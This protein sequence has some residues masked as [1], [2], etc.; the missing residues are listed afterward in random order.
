MMLQYSSNGPAQGS[1]CYVSTGSLSPT[2]A[3]TTIKFDTTVQFSATTNVSYLAGVVGSAVAQSTSPL[4]YSSGNYSAPLAAF[5]FNTTA[6]D[7]RWKCVASVNGATPMVADTGVI[8]TVDGNVHQ[9][10]IFIDDVMSTMHFYIDSA[11]VCL[12]TAWGPKLPAASAV[13]PYLGLYQTSSFGSPQ[14][15]ALAYLWLEANR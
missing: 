5:R 13:T 14:T 6:G 4:T 15:L 3:G 11:E 8:G 12:G 7:A 10:R 1:S 2:W 9:F